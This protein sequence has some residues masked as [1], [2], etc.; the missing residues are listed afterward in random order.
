MK[1][2]YTQAHPDYP[3]PKSRFA[4][5]KGFAINVLI[6]C[7]VVAAIL[8]V[9]W[10]LVAV[11]PYLNGI[12]P[13]FWAKAIVGICGLAVVWFIGGCFREPKNPKL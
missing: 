8:S 3:S 2:Y 5:I 9:R 4:S 7:L 11:T 1:G 6:G 12:M 10:L 13:Y